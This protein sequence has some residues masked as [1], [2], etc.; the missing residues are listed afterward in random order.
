MSAPRNRL[1][2]TSEIDRHLLGVAAQSPPPK[3]D[4]FMRERRRKMA[5][6]KL[7]WDLKYRALAQKALDSDRQLAQA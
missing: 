4:L 5:I 2:T 6:G 3:Y 1:L 7:L